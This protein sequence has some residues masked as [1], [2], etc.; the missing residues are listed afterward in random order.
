M[1]PSMKRGHRVFFVVAI[2]FITVL[3]LGLLT[4]FIPHAQA[5]TAP[6]ATGA[7][8]VGSTYGQVNYYANGYPPKP[9]VLYT[10]NLTD[11]FQWNLTVQEM[12]DHISTIKD[13][14]NALY[15]G[16]DGQMAVEKIDLW[17]NKAH[18]DVADF[19]FL[20]SSGR[21][22]TT[23]GGI[24]G[25]GHIYLYT[26]YAWGKVQQH[27]FGHYGLYLPDEYTDSHGPFCD[28]TQGTGPIPVL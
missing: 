27:E 9:N 3:M 14:N 22:F 25:G 15:D 1:K 26:N 10:F 19:L 13:F 5:Q 11:S 20:S 18:W 12:L 23:R 24:D 8:S 17:N 6:R 28:C 21:S 7:K 4:P 2:T 16:T